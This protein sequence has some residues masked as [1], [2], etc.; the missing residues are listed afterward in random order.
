MTHQQYDRLVT[1]LQAKNRGF[2]KLV[3][4]KFILFACNFWLK[5]N[6]CGQICLHE[7]VMLLF[8]SNI[9]SLTLGST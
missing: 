9:S 3:G 4:L 6:A 7:T 8:A 5:C 2:W 1:W